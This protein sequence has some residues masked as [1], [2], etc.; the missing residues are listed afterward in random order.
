MNNYDND[1]GV[2]NKDNGVKFYFEID[3]INENSKW[4][5]LFSLFYDKIQQENSE[6]RW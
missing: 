5:L 4:P 1:F 2:E 3:L 6:K